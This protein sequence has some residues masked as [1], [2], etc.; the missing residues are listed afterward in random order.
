M[1]SYSR[2][3]E[4]AS[5]IGTSGDFP[6]ATRPKNQFKPEVKVLRRNPSGQSLRSPTDRTPAADQTQRVITRRS[7]QDRGKRR[8]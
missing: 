1:L 3:K 5:R 6:R 7:R 2:R 4:S 8:D